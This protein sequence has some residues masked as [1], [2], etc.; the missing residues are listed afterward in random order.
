MRKAKDQF[1]KTKGDWKFCDSLVTVS[2]LVNIAALRHHGLFV[3]AESQLQLQSNKKRSMNI[4]GSN[5]GKNVDVKDPYD[6]SF[7]PTNN[8]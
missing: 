1:W 8:L 2:V 6:F 7:P 5:R 3:Q 4:N